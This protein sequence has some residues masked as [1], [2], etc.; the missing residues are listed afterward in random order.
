MNERD[1][2][3]PHRIVFLVPG[4]GGDPRCALRDLYRAD[5]ASR[6]TIYD[7]I[8]DIERASDGAGQGLREVLLSDSTSPAM[9]PGI[10]QLA[11]YAVS[12]VL[13]RLLTAAGFRPD[14]IVGQSF[15]EIAALVCAGVFDV[16]D[17]TRAVCA[18]NAAFRGF[19]GRGAMVL[20]LASEPDTRLLLDEVGRSDLVVACVNSPKQTIVSGPADA[21]AALFERQ[22]DGPRLVRLAVPYAS[23]H[24][25]LVVVADRFRAGLRRTRQRPLRVP[26]HSPVGRRTYADTEDLREALVDC[27]VKPVDL[28]KAL[29]HTD[30]PGTTLFIELGVGDGLSR[31]VHATLPAARTLAPLAG[32]LSWLTGTPSKSPV[33]LRQ[34]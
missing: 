2:Q 32:D 29:R 19:E 10:P 26:V 3:P 20:V 5:S 15:G 16:T 7:L 4:Q 8:A 14:V 6:A 34:R 17:G 13:D 1:P 11:S 28:V 18:L 25:G 31:C 23:H 30:T 22:G 27:V 9:A 33:P 24:P 12:V 21:I